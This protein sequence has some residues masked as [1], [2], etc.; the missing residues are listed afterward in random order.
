MARVAFLR[1]CRKWLF[2]FSTR[3][4][5]LKARRIVEM[6]TWTD[7]DIPNSSEE[8][9]MSKRRPK[10]K[11]NRPSVFRQQEEYITLL[12]ERGETFMATRELSQQNS[13]VQYNDFKVKSHI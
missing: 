2:R 8:G 4:E 7:G 3:T 9:C 13:K 10:K 12:L 1:K 11:K 5:L 6:P